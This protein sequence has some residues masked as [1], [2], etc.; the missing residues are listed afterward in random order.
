M[1]EGIVNTEETLLQD[2]LDRRYSCPPMSEQEIASRVEVKNP[3]TIFIGIRSVARGGIT[4]MSRGLANGALGPD[5][6][7][8]Y[9]VDNPFK[10]IMRAQVSAPNE[11]AVYTVPAVPVFADREQYGFY[12]RKE[13]TLDVIEIYRFLKIPLSNVRTFYNMRHPVDTWLSWVKF[14]LH[15]N[16]YRGQLMENYILSVKE[17]YRQY[18]R[19]KRLGIQT[20]AM[21]YESMRDNPPSL[22]MQRL[23]GRL[24]LIYT[25]RIVQG[26]DSGEDPIHYIPYD[27][28][29]Y[30]PT[31]LDGTNLHDK[32]KTSTGLSYQTVPDEQIIQLLRRG[33]ITKEDLERL[34]DTKVEDVYNS[35][36][37]SASEDLGVH[38]DPTH[39]ID[40]LLKV[41]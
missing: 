7:P 26:W 21:V 37:L 16:R 30:T 28:G 18:K 1:S 9:L 39:R 10:S 40:R 6:K 36:A 29:I 5:R 12:T 11:R 2:Q 17:C 35:H 4:A 38:I 3:N 8:I 23:V 34:K 13:A 15:D 19:D 20:T 27:L 14:A 41:A 24:G 32:A 33:F 22:A 31:A 25:D